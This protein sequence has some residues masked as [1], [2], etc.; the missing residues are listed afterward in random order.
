MYLVSWY[1][2]IGNE[3]GRDMLSALGTMIY[4]H[5]LSFSLSILVRTVGHKEHKQSCMGYTEPFPIR[6]NGM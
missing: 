4:K 6:G 3:S 2:Y 1:I 5:I